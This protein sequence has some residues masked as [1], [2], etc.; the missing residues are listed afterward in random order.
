MTFQSNGYTFKPKEMPIMLGSPASPQHP[1]H[2]K[3][4]YLLA[5]F[6]LALAAGLQNG[7]LTAGQLQLRGALGLDLQQDGWVQAAYYM[8]YACMSVLMFKMRQH[9]SIQV[10]TRW[11]MWLLWISALLHVSINGFAHAVAARATAGALACGM[12]V[13]AVFYC[14]QAFDGPKKL[15]GTMLG[16]S[17]MLAALP[18]AQVLVP[19]VFSD[20]NIRGLLWLPLL[21]ALPTWLLMWL[22]PLPPGQRAPSLSWLDW[23]SF[24]LFS[25]GVALLC[26]FLVQGRIVWWTTPWLGYLLCGGIVL[27]GSAL[28]IEN[29]RTKPMLDVSWM[30][31]PQILAFILTAALVR[32]L[33]SE[34][35]VGAAGLM[36]ALGMGG[37]QMVGFYTVVFAASLLAVVIGL[38]RLDLDDIRRPVVVSLLGL[39]IGAYCDIGI[40]LDTRPQQLYF[41]QAL[42]AFSALYFLGPM[43][44]EGLARAMAKSMDHIMSFSALFG[45]SQTV[46]GLAG[47]AG[48][49]ALVT[50]RTREHLTLIGGHLTLTD[51]NVTAHIRTAAYSYAPYSNDMGWLQAQ[52]VSSTAAQ[53]VKQATVLGFNDLFILIFIAAAVSFVGSACLWAWRRYRNIDIL[54][55]EKQRLAALLEP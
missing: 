22:L 45:L 30:M 37:R 32:V 25:G 51:P 20:G 36:A 54:A 10:F 41:S 15:A 11:L 4:A 46:G 38:L 6:W 27:C 13:T 52:G 26:G 31:Q 23:L 24:A 19:L 33:I 55:A 14:M 17:L 5:G 47:A 43:L 39:T 7:F 53:A 12:M 40:G 42:I 50:V 9:Y 8:S 1:P 18:L 28:L 44:L 35:T 21:L 16:L 48:F 49:S 34:Q 2:R 29:Y 3:L